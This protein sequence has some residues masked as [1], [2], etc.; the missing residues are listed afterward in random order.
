M[1]KKFIAFAAAAVCAF[2]FFCFAAAAD[3]DNDADRILDEL[4]KD[5]GADELIYMLPESSENFLSDIGISD[6]RPFSTNGITPNRFVQAVKKA[7]YDNISEPFRAFMFVVAA[8]A[9]AGALDTVKGG[10]ASQKVLMIMSSLSVVLAIS[11]P[12][13]ALVNYLSETITAAGNFML[14]YVPVMAGLMAASGSPSLGA[15]YCGMMIYSSNLVEQACIRL[16]IPLMK[17]ILALS[18][19]SSS[20]SAVRLDG[21]INMFRNAS[22]IIL[23][24]CM[25]LFA[26]FLTMRS[27]VAAAADT[28]ANRAVKFAVSSFVPLVGGALSDAYQ[29]MLSCVSV[30]KSGVGAAAIAAVFALFAVPVIRCMIWQMVTT[31]A[32]AVCDLFGLDRISSLMKSCSFVISVMF[33]I[34]MCTMVMYIIGTAVVLIVGNG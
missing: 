17:C 32:A 9:I 12:L 5:S 1:R 23:T 10:L 14:A 30:L 28:L 8:V 15:S 16:V 3:T 2:R 19:T 11:P 31:T 34:M 13:I 27:L 6:F 7:L 21:V 29:T 25:S 26:S 4:Y 18:I 20:C 22:R 24:F 33:A